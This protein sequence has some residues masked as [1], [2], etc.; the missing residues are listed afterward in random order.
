M[1]YNGFLQKISTRFT[2]LLNE[3]SAGL[4]FDYGPEFE[5]AICTALNAVLPSRFGICR[6]WIVTR[7]GQR[8]GD[9]I[10]IYDRDR[11]STLRLLPSRDFAHKE[12]IPVEAACAYIEA[13]HTLHLLGVGSQSLDKASRQAL[14]ARSL[15]RKARPHGQIEPYM[16]GVLDYEVNEWWP[17]RRNPLFTA[18]FARRVRLD[19]KAPAE[20]TKEEI[21]DGLKQANRDLIQG[22]LEG[23]DKALADAPEG[24]NPD[25]YRPDLLVLG[26]NTVSIPLL[27]V[28]PGKLVFTTPFSLPGK[29]Q[30]WQ[31]NAPG[32]G[33]GMGVCSLLF[34]LD[35]MQLGRMPWSALVHDAMV[36]ANPERAEKFLD[37]SKMD[38]V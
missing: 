26:E 22:I 29:T 24:Q 9:D 16:N 28:P 34:A 21:R 36:T 7:D 38:E 35:S 3:I 32:L 10:I 2:G 11:F 4:N 31:A 14:A 20:A 19:E 27:I 25:S 18:I 30:M 13:K 6:G 17:D 12:E 8:A 15:P 37:V 5:I 33:F 23:E 1:L